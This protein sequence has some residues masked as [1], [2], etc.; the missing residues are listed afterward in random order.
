[1]TKMTT[2]INGTTV[3]LAHG[4]F[5][6]LRSGDICIVL[7]DADSAN[8]LSIFTADNYGKC[9]AHLSRYNDDLTHESKEAKD[10]VAVFN[11][12]NGKEGMEMSKIMHKFYGISTDGLSLDEYI[13]WDYDG[14][15]VKEMTVADIEAI[16]GCKVKIVK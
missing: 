13:V 12:S 15:A 5:V 3:T 1:M 7:A 16:V 6:K 8:G 11:A 9:K 14:A 10:I 4:D 2:I